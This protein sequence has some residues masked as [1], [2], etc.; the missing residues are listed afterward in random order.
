MH[1]TSSVR[2]HV[3]QTEQLD[4]HPCDREGGAGRPLLSKNLQET[5]QKGGK[6]GNDIGEIEGKGQLK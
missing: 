2:P 1:I 5:G 3:P 4:T 6:K